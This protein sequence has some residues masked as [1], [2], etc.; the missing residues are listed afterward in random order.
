MYISHSLKKYFVSDFLESGVELFYTCFLSP[1]YLKCTLVISARLGTLSP[2]LN[3]KQF[4]G[5]DCFIYLSN[6]LSNSL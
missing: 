1:L 5:R 3:C 2:Q 4:L 6:S